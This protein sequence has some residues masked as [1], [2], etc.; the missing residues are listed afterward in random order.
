MPRNCFYHQVDRFFYGGTLVYLLFH[1]LT[2]NPD[3][4]NRLFQNSGIAIIGLILIQILFPRLRASTLANVICAIL[5]LATV[6]HTLYLLLSS[7][8]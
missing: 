3:P 1:F 6:F 2:T 5:I 7:Q 4:L 8:S